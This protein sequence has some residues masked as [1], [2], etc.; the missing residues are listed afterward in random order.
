MVLEHEGFYRNPLDFELFQ[1]FVP[2]LYQEVLNELQEE[3]A[4]VRFL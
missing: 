1:K 4:N 2:W 3:S